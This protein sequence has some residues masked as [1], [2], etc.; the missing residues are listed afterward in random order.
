MNFK[1]G[2]TFR[3]VIRYPYFAQ[4]RDGFIPEG[5]GTIG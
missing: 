4:K 2:L 5:Q 1:P 3:P